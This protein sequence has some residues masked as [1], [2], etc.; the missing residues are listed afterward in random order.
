MPGQCGLNFFRPT[1]I[2]TVPSDRA[3]AAGDSVQGEFI[4]LHLLEVRDVRQLFSQ[5]G[6]ERVDIAGGGCSGDE[7]AP[8]D[9]RVVPGRQSASEAMLPA[10]L[11]QECLG[12]TG[13]A[14]V[15]VRDGVGGPPHLDIGDE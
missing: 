9:E 10:S 6:P 4:D 15:A 12:G 1:M 14:G 13:G 8:L 2:A 11:S 7:V 5:H 3:S